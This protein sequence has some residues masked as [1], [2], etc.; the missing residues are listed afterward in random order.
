MKYKTKRHGWN[1]FGTRFAPYEDVLGLVHEQGYSSIIVPGSGLA[2]FDAFEAN[3]FETSKQRRERTVHGLLEKLD[4][5]TIS[6]QVATIG[7]LDEEGGAEGLR[8]K[9]EKEEDERRIA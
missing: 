2:T 3:P 6:L 7:H 9:E 4:P 5:S 8:A 1:V